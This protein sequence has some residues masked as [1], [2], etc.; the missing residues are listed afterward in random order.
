MEVTRHNF[1]V[2]EYNKIYTLKYKKLESFISVVDE[3][4]QQN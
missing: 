4:L 3:K 1:A 2:T